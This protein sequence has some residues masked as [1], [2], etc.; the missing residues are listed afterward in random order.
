MGQ[1]CP[2]VGFDCVGL[3]QKFF[4]FNESG[5]DSSNY[6]KCVK[7]YQYNFYCIS[8]LFASFFCRVWFCWF[9]N[10]WAVWVG[11]ALFDPGLGRV[12]SIVGLVACSMSASPDVHSIHDHK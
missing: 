2:R 8:A 9:Q 6:K 7:V 5:W 1:V 10:S 3:G 4:T 12:G 11:L